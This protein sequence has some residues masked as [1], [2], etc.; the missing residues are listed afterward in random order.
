MKLLVDH[1]E[2]L[3]RE[4]ARSVAADLNRE[5]RERKL[6]L[7]APLEVEEAALP[8]G[9]LLL[10]REDGEAVAVE[11]KSTLDFVRSVR[12]NRLWEQLLRLGR[13]ERILDHPLRRTLLVVHG[14]FSGYLDSLEVFD[15][16]GGFRRFWASMSGALLETLYVYGVPPLV[17]ETDE[18]LESLLRTLVKREAVG[19]NDSDPEPRWFRDWRKRPWETPSKDDRRLLLSAIPFIGEEVAGTL[20]DHFGSLLAVAQAS[21][22]ELQGVPGVGPERARRIH[23]IFR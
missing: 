11:R 6:R 1:R 2:E 8:L 22:K 7:R 3:L 23:D 9:D 10:I 13:A 5:I 15:A 16:G 14:S 20:L 4:M 19:A 12:D 21:V 18:A 17:A